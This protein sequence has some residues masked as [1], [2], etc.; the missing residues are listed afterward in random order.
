MTGAFLSLVSLDDCKQSF[1]LPVCE[2]WGAFLLQPS[3]TVSQSA[4]GQIMHC[5]LVYV[6]TTCFLVVSVACHH[7]L[8]TPFHCC[9]IVDWGFHLTKSSVALRHH[10]GV[11]TGALVSPSLLVSS[12]L[13]ERETIILFL[14]ANLLTVF[15]YPLLSNTV[16][17]LSLR[18]SST[19]SSSVLESFF[20]SV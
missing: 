1:P 8:S 16:V 17:S 13:M 5:S 2:R 11:L 15:H 19:I 4:M 20:I 12:S 14:I 6:P 3:C 7:R 9:L 10:V 18:C